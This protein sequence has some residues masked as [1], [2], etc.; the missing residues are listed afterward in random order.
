M[1]RGGLVDEIPEPYVVRR[2]VYFKD[3]GTIHLFFSDGNG[4]GHVIELP[5][6]LIVH[7]HS[8]DLIFDDTPVPRRSPLEATLMRGLR[9]AQF[10]PGATDSYS[11]GIVGVTTE[12]RCEDARRCAEQIVSW[13]ESEKY[14]DWPAVREERMRRQA[15]A[16]EREAEQARAAREA[17]DQELAGRRRT[18]AAQGAYTDGDR[19]PKCGFDY[20]WD[21]LACGHCGAKRGGALP[22][23]GDPAAEDR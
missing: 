6:Q 2:V 22:G 23:G 17:R 20:A 18:A 3:G 16:Q 14:L 7:E 8:K 13:V 1:L 19:C 4:H 9:R 21:G 12:A 15:A 5:R 10:D 11:P